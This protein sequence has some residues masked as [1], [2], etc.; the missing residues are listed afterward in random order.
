MS[1]IKT[2]LENSI[3]KVLRSSQ[4]RGCVNHRLTSGT[5]KYLDSITILKESNYRFSKQQLNLVINS[6]YQTKLKKIIKEF[7]D[8]DGWSKEEMEFLGY[9]LIT[10]IITF[11]KVVELQCVLATQNARYFGIS[12]VMLNKLC[13][14]VD[15]IDDLA[16]DMKSFKIKASKG[17]IRYLEM[18]LKRLLASAVDDVI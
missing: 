7:E 4:L 17:D 9:T 8:L 1:V 14:G 12:D 10:C 2:D 6:Q 15:L 13:E 16:T 3:H 5:V 11:L 18:G